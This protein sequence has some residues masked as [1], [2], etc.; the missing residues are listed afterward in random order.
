ML[1]APKNS[2]PMVII[3]FD[4][5][6]LHVRV[7]LFPNQELNPCSLALEVQRLNQLACHAISLMMLLL[8]S[9]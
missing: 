5:T 4:C 7:L 3:I 8:F 2:V 6:M 1:G 9:L